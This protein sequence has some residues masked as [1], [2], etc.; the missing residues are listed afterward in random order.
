MDEAEAEPLHTRR[1][2]PVYE[3]VG[4]VT[5]RMLR[6]MV[7]GVVEAMPA[8][9]EDL[10]PRALR[11]RLGFPERRRAI[12]EAH[13]PPAGTDVARL[14]AFRSAAQ[15]RLIFEEFFLFQ[16]GVLAHRRAADRE[17]KPCVPVVDDRIRSSAAALLPFR[18][19]AG[20]REALRDIVRD[21][22]R[23][24]QMNRLLQGDV[25]SGKT[26]VALIAALVAL[27]NGLQVAMMVPTEILAAQHAETAGRFLAATR[28]GVGLLTGSTPDGR[29]A[30]AVGRTCERKRPARR[31]HPRADRGGR[32]VRAS[33]A[34]DRGRTASFRRDPARAAAREGASARHPG[35][36]GDADSADVAAHGLRR[37]RRVGHPGHA[38]RT[39][40]GEDHGETRGAARRGARVHRRAGGA[41]AAGVRR[42]TRWW[43]HRRR[44]TCVPRRRWRTIWRMTCSAVQRGA[45]ARPD[46]AGGEGRGDASILRPARFTSSWRPPSSR[47][48]S[49]CRT[50]RSWS[51]STP[52]ASAWPSSTNCADGWGAGRTSRIACCSIRNR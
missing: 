35:D 51:S 38:A 31:R 41:G 25:G 10:L 30:G 52:S 19:T 33:R 34:G 12:A 15:W 50:R 29:A 24:S 48:A 4:P 2:V 28:F 3:R 49:T 18:L 27:E 42:S 11:D 6:T 47:W 9:V 44:W 23:P 45:S 43:R 46:D 21:M 1:I 8:D 7:H 5:S 40:A 20:Q 36:D 14:A 39:G 16:C 26:A 22:Q 37:A 17:R 13:F 32:D